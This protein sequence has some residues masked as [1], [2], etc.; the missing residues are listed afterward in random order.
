MAFR[1]QNDSKMDIMFASEKDYSDMQDGGGQG[2]GLY[3]END[4]ELDIKFKEALRG[5]FKL[6][7]QILTQ[8]TT[9]ETSQSQY[10]NRRL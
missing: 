7:N 3:D 1:L 8:F 6:E 2:G 4:S 5:G 9:V 10:I